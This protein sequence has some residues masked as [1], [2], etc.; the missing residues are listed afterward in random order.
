MSVPVTDFAA[1]D[2]CPFCG[3]AKPPLELAHEQEGM[4]VEPE[5]PMPPLAFWIGLGVGLVLACM[6]IVVGF[7]LA[8][9]L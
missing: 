6:A 2:P 9:A 1:Q 8:F 7:L 4:G 5:Y 3:R